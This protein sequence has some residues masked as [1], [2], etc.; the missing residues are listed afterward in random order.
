MVAALS[1]P[2]TMLIASVIVIPFIAAM[3]IGFA[4]FAAFSAALFMDRL[5]SSTFLPRP[6]ALSFVSI[7]FASGG[8]GILISGLPQYPS[9]TETS[10]TLLSV[11]FSSASLIPAAASFSVSPVFWLLRKLFTFL[12]S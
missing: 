2:L 12:K 3:K 1:G 11:P 9:T 7:S 6:M 10:F 4:S 8:N 5:N